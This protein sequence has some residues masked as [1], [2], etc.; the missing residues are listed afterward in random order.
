MAG[1]FQNGV[2]ADSILG[3]AWRKAS[4]SDTFENCVEV[5]R[6][7]DGEVA[8][9]NSRFPKGPA[10]VFTQPEM[11]AFIDGAKKGEFD[12]MTV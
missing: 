10:L 7:M 11:I 12:G 1:E 6:L 8:V 9:R 3:V 2:A 5:A 4:A